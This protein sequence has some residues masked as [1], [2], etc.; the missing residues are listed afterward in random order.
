[1]VKP[2]KS[3]WR[4]Q[5]AVI[6][7]E[8]QKKRLAIDYSETINR[9]TLLDW[10]RLPRIDDTVNKIAQYR[11]FR[12]IDLRSAYHQIPL[13]VEDKSHIAFEACCS[14]HQFNRVPFGVTNRAACFKRI[15]DSFI[16]DENLK[17]TY[18]YLDNVTVCGATQAEH[19]INLERFLQA[20]KRKN[21][22]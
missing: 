16:K 20:A 5:V 4:A 3:P 9:F 1:M 13:K 8:N 6:K 17:C 14:L 22:V 12:T 18:T 15:M 11:V 7:D 19:D 2:C 21:I 10:Y